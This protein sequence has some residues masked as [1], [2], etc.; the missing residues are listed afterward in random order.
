VQLLRPSGD[1]LEAQRTDLERQLHKVEEEAA[2]LATAM[3]RGG[4]LQALLDALQDRERQQA[5]LRQQ[6]AGLAGLRQVSD[7]DVRKIEK[8][9]R[10]RLDDWRGLLRHTPLSRQ[11]VTKLLDGRLVFTPRPEDRA[12]EFTGQAQLGKL[13]RGI[14]LPQVFDRFV[15]T[16]AQNAVCDA[17]LEAFAEYEETA[18][19]NA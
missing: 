9:L 2:N 18:A 11:V 14:V 5:H 17:I 4:N 15:D 3:A 6:L 8:A 12:Y 13:L 19:S 10:A 7:F 1:T 16:T